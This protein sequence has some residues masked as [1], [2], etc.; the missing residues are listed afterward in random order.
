MSNDKREYDRDQPVAL[1]DRD[2]SNSEVE[3]LTGPLDADDDVFRRLT[4][5]QG[6]LRETAPV[7]EPR[8]GD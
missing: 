6:D 7:H 3:E 2:P 5:D 1:D 4:P 8:Y